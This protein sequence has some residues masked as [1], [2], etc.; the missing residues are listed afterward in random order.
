MGLIFGYNTNGWQC[1]DWR[2]TLRLL[3]EF[4]YT[5]VAL[6]IDVHLLNPSARDF[7]RQLEEV[8]TELRRLGLRSVIE[9]GARFLLNPR[10]KH[11][12]TLLHPD[13]VRREQRL[14]FL[15]QCLDIAAALDSDCVS[16]WSG[17][18]RERHATGAWDRLAGE[19]QQ[20]VRAAADRQV[21][22]AFE[23]E[24]G[25]LVA[26]SN[27]LRELMA[28]VPSPWLGCTLDIGH[29]HCLQEGSLPAVIRDW[30]DLLWNVHIEDMR[31]GVHDHLRFGEGEIDFPPVLNALHDIRYHH[32]VYVEL[33]RH[34]HM[35]PTA[36][37]ESIAF[38]QSA[39][40]T[41]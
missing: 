1:H 12:P 27:D 10:L 40:K 11:S 16:L 9:T 34:S 26:T 7:S 23:P 8:H 38:L 22:L 41:M 14:S 35:A 5:A 28:R 19:M 32:G 37:A 24:P 31:A 4:D 17:P 15:V 29:V 2:D 13:P 20:L 25:F 39:E 30:G 33:S 3:K 36:A 21:R 18:L 6:T